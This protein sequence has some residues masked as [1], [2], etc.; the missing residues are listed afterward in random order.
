LSLQ[1]IVQISKQ[2][3]L[4]ENG[5]WFVSLPKQIAFKILQKNIARAYSLRFDEFDRHENSLK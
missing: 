1:P 3:L 5:T 2:P 4:S